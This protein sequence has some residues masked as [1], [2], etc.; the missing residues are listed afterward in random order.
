M[1]VTTTT[2]FLITLKPHIPQPGWLM[3]F[4]SEL[5]YDE[6]VLKLYPRKKKKCRIINSVITRPG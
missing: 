5:E 3:Y 1:C 6:L 2:F 4:N